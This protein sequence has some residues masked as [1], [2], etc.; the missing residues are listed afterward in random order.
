MVQY[1]P[2]GKIK[3]F[4]FPLLLQEKTIISLQTEQTKQK[5]QKKSSQTKLII[6]LISLIVPN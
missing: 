2:L 4:L 3:I 1:Y 5:Q 6:H